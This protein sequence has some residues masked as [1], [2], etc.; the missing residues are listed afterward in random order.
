MR[1]VGLV[2]PYFRTR[3]ATE[4][5]FP[6]LG[7]AYLAAQLKNRNIE[8]RIF[9]CTFQSFRK[10]SKELADYHPDVVGISSMILLGR[11]TFRFAEFVRDQLPTALLV[12]GG[13]MPTFIPSVMPG[14]LT[15][16]F[17]VNRPKLP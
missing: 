8:T 14:K 15:W 4:M 2:F 9:D 10:V 16:F 5:L 13:P 12:V 11:N 17:A 3:S 1:K 7:L 6:P